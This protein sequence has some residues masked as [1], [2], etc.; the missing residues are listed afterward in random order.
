MLC[1]RQFANR[2][3]DATNKIP[4]FKIQRAFKSQL[5]SQSH[6]PKCVL[7]K[8][9]STS[10]CYHNVFNLKVKK[11]N[12]R[13]YFNSQDSIPDSNFNLN[14]QRSQPVKL[15]IVIDRIRSL[16]VIEIVKKGCYGCEH[17]LFSNQH[18]YCKSE[19]DAGICVAKT[20]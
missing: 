6:K 17:G 8:D 3:T 10:V 2:K 18:P 16:N 11:Q 5:T 13:Y 1:A 12:N 9:Y 19:T 4:N 20:K 7:S 15:K 14:F